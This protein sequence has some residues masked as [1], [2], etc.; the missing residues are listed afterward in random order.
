MFLQDSF[1]IKLGTFEVT[2]VFPKLFP[3]IS[4][5]VLS[6]FKASDFTLFSITD[7]FTPLGSSSLLFK[8]DSARPF[9][10]FLTDAFPFAS[11]VVETS[12]FDQSYFIPIALYSADDFK[13][14]G[15]LSLTLKLGS[16]RFV[17][18]L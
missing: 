11:L 16:A 3:E 8:L 15:A 10:L 18:L 14:L 7:D 2:V 12:L 4:S 6:I 13:Q 17:T 5:I 1:E 9:I